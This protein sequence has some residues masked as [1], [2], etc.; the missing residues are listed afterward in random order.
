MQ[1]SLMK[2]ET[3]EVQYEVDAIQQLKTMK[4]NL[5]RQVYLVRQAQNQRDDTNKIQ[6][7]IKAV[8][9]INLRRHEL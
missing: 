6:S 7:N 2:A 3:K 8:K 4:E 5:C 9:A 1:P